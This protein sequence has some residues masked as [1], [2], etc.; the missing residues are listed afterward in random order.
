MGSSLRVQ[1]SALLAFLLEIVQQVGIGGVRLLL[2]SAMDWRSRWCLERVMGGGGAL[3]RVDRGEMVLLLFFI[4]LFVN[5]IIVIVKQDSAR[6]MEA[7]DRDP[8]QEAIA[9]TCTKEAD[10]APVVRW[11]DCDGSNNVVVVVVDV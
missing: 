8:M 3:Y 5:D 11:C 9:Y 6:F 2:F 4:L 7:R 1:F 10:A